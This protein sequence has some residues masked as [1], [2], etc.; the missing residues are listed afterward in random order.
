MERSPTL[1]TERLILRPLELA[2]AEAIQQHFPHW[3]VVRYLNA[4][5]PWPYPADGAL[6]YLRDIAL[7]AIARGEEWH[8]SIRLKSAPEQLIG[9]VSLMNEP[10]NNR[11]F[12]LSPQWQGQG[13]M[14]EASAAVTQYWFETLDR[15]LLRVPKAAPNLASRRLS[16][17]TGMRLIHCDEGDFVGGRFPRELWEITRE[18]WRRLR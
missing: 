6:A 12:W 7:P 9:N 4:L 16:E 1:Y 2:D 10:D 8:W 17:R 3:E 11:G 18:E 5:V 14:S 13:L 15:S